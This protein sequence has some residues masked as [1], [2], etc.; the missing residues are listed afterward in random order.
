MK[1]S[2]NDLN[3]RDSQKPFILN[4]LILYGKFYIHKYKWTQQILKIHQYKLEIEHY[5]Q[6]LHGPQ[7]K[8]A[9]ETLNI[10]EA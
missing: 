5:F 3:W 2:E 8:K 10:S 9:M 1:L 4:L 7:D 6:S